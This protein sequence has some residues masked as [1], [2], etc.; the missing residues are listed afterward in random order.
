ML[1]RP[2]RQSRVAG[3]KKD[4]MVEVGAGQTQRAL[5]TGERDPGFGAEIFF[6]FAAGGFAG[7]D[8]NLE[9]VV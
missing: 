6:A 3:R 1:F 2:P 9:V 8:K 4:Q 7:R 5:L